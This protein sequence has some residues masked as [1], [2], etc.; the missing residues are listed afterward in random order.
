MGDVQ[1]YYRN[2]ARVCPRPAM[3]HQEFWSL[4]QSHPLHRGSHFQ[5]RVRRCVS[6][7]EGDGGS[8][9]HG[10]DLGGWWPRLPR[11]VWP[12]QTMRQVLLTGTVWTESILSCTAADRDWDCSPCSF[13]RRLLSPAGRSSE[14]LSELCCVCVSVYACTCVCLLVVKAKPRDGQS[15]G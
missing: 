11:P 9:Q 12:Q 15:N 3:N 6:H 5:G 4:L 2:L 10:P 8:W 1:K 7:L 14:G 13:S